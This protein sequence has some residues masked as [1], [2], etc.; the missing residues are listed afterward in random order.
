MRLAISVVLLT[1]ALVLLQSA[2]AGSPKNDSKSA[3]AKVYVCPMPEH[4]QE[5][6]KPGTCP[7]CGMELVEKDKRFRV[8]VLVFDY[9]EDIDFTAPIEV[10]GESGA[11]VFT[12][13]ATK[14]PIRT[15]FGLRITPDYDLEHA[16]PSDV[17]LVPGGGVGNTLHNDKV[18][19]WIAQRAKQS[20]YVMSVCNGAFIIAKAGLLDGL[21]ATTTA[22]HIDE[23]AEFSPTTRVLRQRVVDNGKV[24]TAGGLSSGIDGAF[25]LLERE[26]GRHRAEDVAR[27]MEYHWQ[28]E[29]S[30]SRANDAD[31]RLPDVKL[32]EK[33]NWQKI[34]SHGDTNQWEVS[35]RLFIPMSQDE[36]LDYST[37]QIVAK[38]WTLRDSEKGKR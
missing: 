33:A 22:S 2:A 23:L 9:A 18:I 14:A 28:P 19:S 37:K 8:A 1:I 32:P 36:F 31:L 26:F 12:V 13:A 35:G 3:P 25:H 30:W 5:F 38:G 11:E 21:S 27:G 16:P 6:D 10:F 24:I 7:L 4:A 20:R 29:S 34:S 17:L 15:V